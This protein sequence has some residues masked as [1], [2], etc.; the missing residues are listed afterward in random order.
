MIRRMLFRT[1]PVVIVALLLLIFNPSEKSL[2]AHLSNK[3]WVPLQ[4]QRTNCLLFSW[5]VVTG[6]TGAKGKFI[7][8]AGR[9]FEF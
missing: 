4:V 1:G 8:I 9:Y 6:L 7:G 3:G 5:N 2:R